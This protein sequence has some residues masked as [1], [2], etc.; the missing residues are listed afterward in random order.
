[1]TRVNSFYIKTSNFSDYKK[2]LIAERKK[3]FDKNN[4]RPI[5]AYLQAHLAQYKSLNM[6]KHPMYSQQV[7]LK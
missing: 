1:M 2:N 6:L 4:E 3:T 7:I 5:T